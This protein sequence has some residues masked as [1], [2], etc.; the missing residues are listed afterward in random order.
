LLS[1]DPEFSQVGTQTH[2]NYLKAFKQYRDMIILEADT[3]TYRTILSSINISV[4]G[5]D[6]IP[7]QPSSVHCGGDGESEDEIEEYRRQL[8]TDHELPVVPNSDP[9]DNDTNPLTLSPSFPVLIVSESH[10]PNV[11]TPAQQE[12]EE[13]CPPVP[14][15]KKRPAPRRKKAT[16]PSNPVLEN[17]VPESSTAEQPIVT[18]RTSRRTRA[19]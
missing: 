5:K 16:N 1:P 18:T 2:V 13:E 7:A 15:P 17:P 14:E 12:V 11:V 6:Y 9:T 10:P 8:N 3:P 19:K 4:L